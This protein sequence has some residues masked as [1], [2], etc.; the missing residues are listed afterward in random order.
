MA[1]PVIG[2]TRLSDAAV[3]ASGSVPEAEDD[4]LNRETGREDAG[5]RRKRIETLLI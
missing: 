2:K 5:A 1:V 4:P 3:P